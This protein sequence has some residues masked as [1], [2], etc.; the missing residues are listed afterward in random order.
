MKLDSATKLQVLSNISKSHE[1]RVQRL[2]ECTCFG[3]CG[4]VVADEILVEI[5]QNPCALIK[6]GQ[7]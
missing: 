6:V 7:C 2:A 5:V 4:L 3:E 1:C